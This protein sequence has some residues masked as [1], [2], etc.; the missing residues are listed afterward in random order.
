MRAEHPLLGCS[1]LGHMPNMVVSMPRASPCVFGKLGAPFPS[2]IFPIFILYYISNNVT[3]SD[4]YKIQS[5][6]NSF[7]MVLGGR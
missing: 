6:L 1:A 5:V 2:A 4:C 3:L 7:S